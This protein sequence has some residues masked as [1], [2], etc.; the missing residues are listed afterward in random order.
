VV[1]RGDGLTG[2]SVL[3]KLKKQCE[4]IVNS[5]EIDEY[6]FEVRCEVL[7]NKNL[8][9]FK[10]SD[11]Y[12]NARNYVAGI[13]GKDDIDLIQ[14]AELTVMPLQIVVEGHNAA[15]IC[16]EGSSEFLYP[17]ES[18]DYKKVISKYI[19]YRE[20]CDF[21][22]DGIVFTFPAEYRSILGEN[23]HDPEWAIAVKYIPD[24]AISTV[25]NI[26]WQIG[27]TGE[28]TPVINISPVELAGTVVSRASAYN[29]GY[30]INKKIGVG[31]KLEIIK[32]GDII[33][34]VKN[35]LQASNDITYP[36]IC[37]YCGSDTYVDE[38]HLMCSNMKCKGVSLKKISEMS[39]ILNIKG[40]GPATCELFAS[41]CSTS[42]ELLIMLKSMLNTDDKLFEKYGFDINSKSFDNFKNAINSI[43]S[44][45]SQQLIQL[46]NYNNL[47][48]SL[49][50]EL[51][52]FYD[53]NDGCF[54]GHE[55]K[56]VDLFT[57]DS[58]IEYYNSMV[59][60][61]NS[62]GIEVL[63]YEKPSED[64]I[65]VE[66]TGSPK[67]F[68]FK[69]KS[70]WLQSHGGKVMTCGLSDKNCKYLITD[71]LNSTSSKMKA[72]IKKGIK[73]VTYNYN[74]WYLY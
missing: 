38:I 21:L 39:K 24:V 2:K 65:W 55:K 62:V 3:N 32:A 68:G 51:S 70:E 60:R 33:P 67:N 64:I 40:I 16:I 6:N 22:L 63:K 52:K 23:D 74:F 29:Y 37:P 4:D 20:T 36:N 49:S 61:L 17:Y 14:C 73:I 1:T 18:L 72:A 5:L 57:S 19:E 7:I 27:K 42:I 71:D 46:Y 45:S 59:A 8:F 28:F 13:L 41:S 69:S 25:N 35:V 43:K 11:T 48:E 54:F 30:V 10:Y 26:N 12:A 47:G 15:D 56:I 31:A 44:I 34:E 9:N 50:K 66:L 53:A 58:Y